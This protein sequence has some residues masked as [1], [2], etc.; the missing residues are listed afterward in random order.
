MEGPHPGCP[1]GGGSGEMG[2]PHPRTAGWRAGESRGQVRDRHPGLPRAGRGRG[3]RGGVRTP[4]RA[5]AGGGRRGGGAGWG[6]RRTARVWSFAR[7]DELSIRTPSPECL[8]LPFPGPSAGCSSEGE[9]GENVWWAPCCR[10][11]VLLMQFS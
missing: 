8:R 5:R 9:P 2:G 4:A 1:V 10:G 6:A 11:S 3:P 7:R